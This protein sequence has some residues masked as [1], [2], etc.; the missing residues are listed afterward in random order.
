MLANDESAFKYSIFPTKVATARQRQR[1]T[2]RKK[3][4]VCKTKSGI[5][6]VIAIVK[7]TQQKFC[8]QKQCVVC[9]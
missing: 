7:W 4:H 9:G 3:S 8:F 1:V 2:L 6:V 5:V